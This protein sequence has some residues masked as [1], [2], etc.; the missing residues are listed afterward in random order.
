[1]PSLWNRFPSESNYLSPMLRAIS[2]KMAVKKIN[3]TFINKYSL[4]AT[5]N[6]LGNLNRGHY[7]AC[8][9]DLHSSCWYSCN[10]KLVFNVEESS[11]NNTISLQKSVN[12]FQDLLKYILQGGFVISDI[13]FGSNDHTYNPSPVWELSLLTQFSGIATAQS[14]VSEKQCKGA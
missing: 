14:L 2:L 12:F 4:I 3:K 11:L 6:H 10:D 7:W 1:M 13:V 5:I 9:K 8:I